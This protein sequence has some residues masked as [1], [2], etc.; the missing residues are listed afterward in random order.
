MTMFEIQEAAKVITESIDPD[1]RVIFGAIKDPNLK[2]D[3]LKVTVIA[4][5]F[6]NES[7]GKGG[8]PVKRQKINEVN[9]TPSITKTFVQEI[10]N[11]LKKEE[12]IEVSI[13]PA[14]AEQSEEDDENWSSVPAFLRRSSKK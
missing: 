12:K 8:D 14:N 5:G 13:T 10:K 6:P 3:E 11:N 9:E 2:K 7:F 4:T 1:A